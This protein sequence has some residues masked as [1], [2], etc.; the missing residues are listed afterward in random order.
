MLTFL[1]RATKDPAS[2][3]PYVLEWGDWLES[4]ESLA[5]ANVEVTS[6][7]ILGDGT[8]GA[9]APEISQTRVKMWLIGG[10]A[11]ATYSATTT[12]TT[13]PSPPKTDKRT[14]AVAVQER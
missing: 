7:L 6:G 5:S 9:P 13:Q 4:G 1:A 8:N 3:L 11:G 2:V 10:V 12:I 14:I